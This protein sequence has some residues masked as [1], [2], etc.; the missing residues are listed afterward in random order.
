MSAVAVLGRTSAI[1]DLVGEKLAESHVR[2]VLDG[3]FGE[4]KLAPRFA[5]LAP[6]RAV[7]P[8]YRLFLECDRVDAVL[9]RQ[10]ASLVE[11][12][13]RQNPH[14][15]Y[16]VA[17][18]QLASCRSDADLK[19]L[20]ESAGERSNFS[21]KREDAGLAISSRWLWTAHVI[22]CGC[23]QPRIARRRR[24]CRFHDS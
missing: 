9:R 2:K 7:D 24:S 6:D 18:R 11:Q 10:V 14:Y 21:L 16:A 3:L 8:G 13:L 15:R 12:G 17:I 1:S 22:G 19:V 4:L 5:M 20:R 23:L